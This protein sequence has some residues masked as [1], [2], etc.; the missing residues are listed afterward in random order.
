MRTVA[1]EVTRKRSSLTLRIAFPAPPVLFRYGP[2]ALFPSSPVPRGARNL[3]ANA[4][5][6]AWAKIILLNEDQIQRCLSLGGYFLLAEAALLRGAQFLNSRK[7]V[8]S[9]LLPD[10]CKSQFE[11]E[12]RLHV[13]CQF[14]YRFEDLSLART[15]FSS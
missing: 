2:D 6:A 7:F 13:R 14:S 5:T 9:A 3:F 1:G 8:S 10:W 15:R 11:T 12:M 4:L